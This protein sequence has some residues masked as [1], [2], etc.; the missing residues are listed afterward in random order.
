M[1]S[2]DE[3]SLTIDSLEPGMLYRIFWA[4]PID[5]GTHGVAR[6][7][8]VDRFVRM[9]VESD[10]QLYTVWDEQD[11]MDARHIVY[12]RPAKHRD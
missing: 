2:T 11:R 7:E 3:L 10:R 5:S 6:G 1:L 12:I 4:C 8:F 9:T